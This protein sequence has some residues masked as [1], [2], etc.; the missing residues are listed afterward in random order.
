MLMLRFGNVL[1][2]NMWDRKSVSSVQISFKEDFGTLGR[3]GYFDNYG[4]IRDILQNHLMQVCVVVCCCCCWL[5]GFLTEDYT[6]LIKQQTVYIEFNV[7]NRCTIKHISIHIS[8]INIQIYTYIYIYMHTYIY[9]IKVL[10][11]VAMDEPSQVFGP[12]AGNA[13]RDAKV[14]VI[15]KIK[16][17]DVKDVVVGQYG[18]DPKGK[19]PA[20][21]DDPTVRVLYC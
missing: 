17:I 4:I 12:E 9:K 16:P 1:F 10:A 20:Y 18:A 11:L 3:G 2:R 5:V 21:I 7:F 19:E 14:A 13:I 8:Q 15:K 6:H